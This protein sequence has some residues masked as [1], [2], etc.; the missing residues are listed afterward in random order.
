MAGALQPA[1]NATAPGSAAATPPAGSCILPGAV[2]AGSHGVTGVFA[3]PGICGTGQAGSRLQPVTPQLTKTASGRLRSARGAAASGR[4]HAGQPQGAAAGY[5][6]L[7]A[8]YTA[9]EAAQVMPGAPAAVP[10]AATPPGFGGSVGAAGTVL[11]V[12]TP[13]AAAALPMGL[14]AG[15]QG[16]QVSCV[17]S[18]GA[19][20]GGA[21]LPFQGHVL[22]VTAPS[23]AP[24]G[25][26]AAPQPA[27]APAPPLAAVA[28]TAAPP[29]AAAGTHLSEPQQHPSDAPGAISSSKMQP[30]VQ[31]PSNQAPL[32]GSGAVAAAVAAIVAAAGGTD[33]SRPLA[34]PAPAVGRAASPC[35]A[36]YVTLSTNIPRAP[37]PNST[38][39][40]ARGGVSQASG[41]YMA[42]PAL[43]GAVTAAPAAAGTPLPVQASG[44]P[45]LDGGTSTTAAAVQAAVAAAAAAAAA[46]HHAA[47][48]VPDA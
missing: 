5:G 36:D 43:P 20:R 33:S 23:G 38:L 24:G 46:A 1:A 16:T 6:P 34:D 11:L 7:G 25:P 44:A 48:M 22:S 35:P 9:T 45:L 41:V 18:V 2:A 21:L 30:A 19:G 4:V 17:G 28:P 32:D 42:M 10:A 15:G 12:N 14:L 27:L 31:P 40:M 37:T 47:G 39:S 29:A 8:A 13:P 26:A 3:A